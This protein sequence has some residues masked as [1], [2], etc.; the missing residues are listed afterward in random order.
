MAAG[1]EAPE[2]PVAAG[3][4]P[5]LMGPAAVV[6]GA[7]E[8]VGRAL[9]AKLAADGWHVVL[10]ARTPET[11]EAATAEAQQRLKPGREA[12]AVPCDI[13]DEAS[14]AALREAAER[15]FADVR[16]VVCCAGV[17]CTGDFLSHSLQDFEAQMSV[18]FL[19]HVA[20]AQAFLPGL[21]ERAGRGGKKPT[22]C[23][24][25]SFG[26]RVPL[27]SMTAYTASKYALQGFADSLRIEAEAKGVHVATVHPGVIRSDFLKRAQW[28]GSEGETRRDAMG[29]ILD[30]SAPTSGLMTQSVEEVADGVL[31]ALNSQRSE[32]VVGA[33]FKALLGGYSIG[34]ALG[35]A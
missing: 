8:G 28:R 34:K 33:A 5:P 13:T 18:N 15:R 20:T 11:L 35:V 17:C 26:G 22:L 4:P 9:A 12:L 1:R 21:V 2:A 10:A 7:S 24:V 3:P 25:N 19:G 6:T 27:P 14:V 30:G 32:V 23:F 16:A 29:K 31:E